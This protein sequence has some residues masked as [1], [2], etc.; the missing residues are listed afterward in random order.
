MIHSEHGLIVFID[1]Q[2]TEQVNSNTESVGVLC[3]IVTDK[4]GIKGLKQYK[5]VPSAERVKLCEGIARTLTMNENR[6]IACISRFSQIQRLSQEF[7]ESMPETVAKKKGNRYYIGSKR[8]NEKVAQVLP[9]YGVGLS[10]IA[11]RCIPWAKKFNLNKLTLIIDKL[12]GDASNSM[13]FLRRMTLHPEVAEELIKVQK[14]FGV[15]VSV[16][17]MDAFSDG[18]TLIDDPNCHHGMV[19][20]DWVAHSIYAASNKVEELDKPAKRN[21]DYRLEL[22]KIWNEMRKANLAD[23]IPIDNISLK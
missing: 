15:I 5:E 3:G 12:P 4:N 19:I 23:I 22:S 2:P 10:A 18:E 8:I 17:N 9:W 7:L 20:A 14:K 11:I 6:A 16:A 21:E 1:M 13:E